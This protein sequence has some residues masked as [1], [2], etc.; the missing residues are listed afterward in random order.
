ME[1]VSWNPASPSECPMGSSPLSTSKE[2]LPT[3]RVVLCSRGLCRADYV[4]SVLTVCQR[5]GM[6]NWLWEDSGK[7]KCREGRH[8]KLTL[9]GKGSQGAGLFVAWLPHARG[10]EFT[11]SQNH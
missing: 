4:A 1:R 10:V 3:S 11:E 5:S 9:V 2:S 7:D 6:A 8:K